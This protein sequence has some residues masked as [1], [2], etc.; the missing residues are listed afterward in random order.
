M[1][2]TMMPIIGT[3]A[4]DS[5]LPRQIASRDAE[6]LRRYRE[7]LTT[8]RDVEVRRRIAHASAR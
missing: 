6:R 2:T 5:P 3:S 7:Y 1:T 8:R 4:T